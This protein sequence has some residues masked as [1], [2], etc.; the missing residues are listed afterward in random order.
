[1]TRTLPFACAFLAA[2]SLMS[3][4]RTAQDRPA[5]PAN[6]AC[7][8]DADEDNPHISSDLRTLYYASNPKGQ[9]DLF[10]ATRPTTARPWSKGQLLEDYVSTNVDDRSAFAT[11]EGRFPQYFYFATKKDKEIDNFDI[12]VAVKQ[13]AGKAF[14]APTPINPIATAEEEMHPWLTSNGQRLYFSRKTKEGWRVLCSDRQAT[15]GAAGFGDPKLV[16]ELPANYHH[17]TLTPDGKT[18]YL[19]GPLEKDRCGLFVSA[20]DGSKWGKPEALE[21]NHRDAPT[22]DL[23]PCLSRDGSILYFASDRPGGK[24]KL[25][26]WWVHT[27]KL[28][29]AAPK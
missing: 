21:I 1:M 22:G 26:L 2:L 20:W 24:G 27:A 14:S 5:E 9:F 8:T 7:N 4:G 28:K 19:Q 11:T 10:F 29:K 25:D 23:S 16:E 18:M 15:T 6:L 13:G 3:P 17:A 12:Y